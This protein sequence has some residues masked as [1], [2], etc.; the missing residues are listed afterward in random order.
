MKSTARFA[1]LLYLQASLLGVVSYIYV[2]RTLFVPGDA[3]AT[4]LNISAATMLYRAG[5][6]SSLLSDLLLILL[7][8]TLYRLFEQV[9]RKNGRL[10]VVL[11]AV[12]A[13][14]GIANVL[15][16]LAPLIL[17]SG[18]DF[19]SVFT[20]PQL[21][22]LTMAF[23]RLRGSGL[24]LAEIFWGLWL[25]PFGML[26]IRSGF[27]PRVG[28]LLLVSCLAYE[29]SVLAF[30]LWPAHSTMVG[31]LMQP[32]E[33]LGE[34]LAIF[35]LLFRTPGPDSPSRTDVESGAG[36]GPHPGKILS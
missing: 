13:G 25:F 9:D 35:S 30:I 19:L 20:K 24:V 28:R 8:L 33:G 23:L 2:P 22:A 5:I 12:G 3:S 4:A 17:L 27:F 34:A 11:L 7:G 15:N 16:L 18:A 31:R 6:L 10:L 36:I 14:V 1:G 21:D 29:V 26:A 32:L